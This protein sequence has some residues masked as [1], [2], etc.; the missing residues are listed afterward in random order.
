MGVC[1]AELYNNLGLCCFWAQQVFASL[2]QIACLP[3]H[4]FVHQSRW[5]SFASDSASGAWQYQQVDCSIGTRWIMFWQRWEWKGIAVEQ[6][7]CQCY[8]E[9]A[10]TDGWGCAF[11][12]WL[13]PV[14][15][16]LGRRC[17]MTWLW[18]ASSARCRWLGTK[19]CPTCGTICHTLHCR[20]AILT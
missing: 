7:T 19:P 1:S 15:S 18:A 13:L 5:L 11:I 12:H 6:H 2:P 17:S 4:L 20:W 8:A 10:A 14:A 9:M 3:H 16:P